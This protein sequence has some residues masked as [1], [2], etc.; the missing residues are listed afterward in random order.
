ME[1]VETE[2]MKDPY[3]PKFLKYIELF[4]QIGDNR[5]LFPKKC[6]TCGKVYKNFPE[7]IHNTSP[8]AHGL[9]EFTNSLNIQHTMQY[10][11]CSCGSTLAILF[12][13]EDYPLLDSF[14][15]MIGKESKETKKPVREVVGEFREQCNRYIL[16]NR[17]KEGQ[18]S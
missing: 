18:D 7:Y 3:N 14:W 15:E 8:L 12:T 16:E 5:R 4:A 13:K 6:R 17:D 9:E 10:R 1:S 2:A 11:H